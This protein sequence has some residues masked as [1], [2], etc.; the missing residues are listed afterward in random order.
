M[1]RRMLFLFL[2][3]TFFLATWA[4]PKDDE[5]TRIARLSYVDGN[6]SFQHSSDTDWSAA[7]INLPMEPGDRIYTG[8]EGRAEI[9]FDDGSVFHLAENTDM[10]ILSLREGLIQMRMMLG[11]AT[12]TV[13]SNVDFEI[14]TPAAAFNVLSKG[15]FRF[16]VVE[17]G[18]TDAIVR[19]GKLEA[20]TN[21]FSRRIE[22]GEMLHISPGAQNPLL[23]RYDARDKWDEWTDRRNADRIAYESRKYMPA[24]V[25]MGASELDQYGHWVYVD[26]YGA[27]WVPFSVDA[28]WSPYSVGRW[29]YRPFYGWTWVSYEP[30]G[31][32]PYH[33][34]RWYYSGRFGWCWLPGPSFAFNFWSPALVTFYSGS[35]WISWCPLG[36]GDWYDINRYHYNRK[37][38]YYQLARL[39]AL[40]TRAPGN[41]FNRGSRGAFRTVLVD[42][43]R[44]GS[45]HGRESS[46]LWRN[47][48]QPWRRGALIKDRLPVK[49]VAGS[50]RAVTDRPVVKPSGYRT[51]PAVVR[52]NPGTRTGS[53]D[54]IKVITNPKTA[55][56]PTRAIQNSN[57]RRV[58]DARTS[59]KPAGRVVQTP[60][61]NQTN[62]NVRTPSGNNSTNQNGRRVT[63]PQRNESRP[64]AGNRNESVQ[65]SNSPN[66]SGSNTR[67]TQQNPSRQRY[68]NKAPNQKQTPK[69]APKER[70]QNKA[71]EQNQTRKNSS[72][73]QTR[74][75]E[76]R[77]YGYGRS[78]SNVSR[79]WSRTN[80]QSSA[81][82]QYR[83]Q[84]RPQYKYSESRP[85]MST[86]RSNSP[87]YSRNSNAGNTSRYSAPQP[88]RQTF[89]APQ[90]S[91]QTFSAPQPSRQT[92]GTPRQASPTFK[93]NSNSGRSFSVPSSP[94]S[95]R[96]SAPS[97]GRSS[98]G[99][100]SSRGSS[101]SQRSTNSGSSSRSARRR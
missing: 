49:P 92:L 88:S 10:E 89:R 65:R 81:S 44:N 48:D 15:V 52:N 97:S 62:R 68:E 71:P 21:E 60:Q 56:P 53:R 12:L 23:S 33:Y 99:W 1:T 29:C 76:R 19:A 27:A 55:T 93:Q 38:Y 91:R 78:Q 30:W 73:V 100:S 95:G 32:L 51:L 36:P 82:T 25:Y 31:W 50:Y 4:Y 46:N 80:S 84:A 16:D 85:N 64:T 9:E 77:Q 40:H 5:Y 86:G 37:L 35:G 58:Q 28:Y 67:S 39:R 69:N 13:S 3:T 45:F 43:F 2:A 57:V 74:N 79:E 11:L 8:Q 59:S 6:V 22:A 7:S 98:G 26:T 34:G 17:S 70:N 42:Q 54:R 101:G 14:N 24:T 61:R 47:V 83:N 20:A 87:S 96:F 90:Q 18:D 72:A 41:P 63:T 94:V 75:E 66:R